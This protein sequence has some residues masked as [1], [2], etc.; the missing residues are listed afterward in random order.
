MFL[1]SKQSVGRSEYSFADRTPPYLVSAIP[2]SFHLIYSQSSPVDWAL[3]TNYLSIYL[4][5]SSTAVEYVI[6]GKSDFYLWQQYISFE[7]IV[8]VCWT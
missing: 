3:K 7:I 4:L 8:M 1:R 6:D 5:Q 2:D